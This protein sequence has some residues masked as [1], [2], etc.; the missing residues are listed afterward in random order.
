MGE[1][2]LPKVEKIKVIFANQDC[3]FLKTSQ[4]N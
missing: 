3:K 1:I 2:E 4:K